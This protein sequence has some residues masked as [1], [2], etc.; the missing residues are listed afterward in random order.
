MRLRGSETVALAVAGL[1]IVVIFSWFPYFF[2]QA[3]AGQITV[4]YEG[5]RVINLGVCPFHV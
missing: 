1:K 2:L 4:N 3:S 5:L